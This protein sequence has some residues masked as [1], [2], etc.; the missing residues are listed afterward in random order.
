MVHPSKHL[1]AAFALLL[2]FAALP[3]HAADNNSLVGRWFT[4]GVENG[5]YLQVFL[6]NKA[7]GTYVKDV[8][9]IDK[10]EAAGSGKETGKWTYE[11]GDLAT[12]S[13][14]LDGKP[15]TGSFADTHDLF[16]VTRVDESHINLYDTETN[17]TWALSLVPASATFPAPRGCSV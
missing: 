9:A 17:I 5:V 7:D 3:S 14:M 13:Q 16:T 10:C 8:R 11:K 1:F 15:V 12:E 2:F 4:E 6:D